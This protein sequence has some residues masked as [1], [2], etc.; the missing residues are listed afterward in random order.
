MVSDRD[1]VIDAAFRAHAADIY[2]LAF[3]I[4]RE[5]QAAEDVTQDT[6]ARAYDRF[7]AY[8]PS[9][10]IKGWLHAIATHLA[11]DQLRHARVRGWVGLRAPRAIATC[12]PSVQDDTGGIAE[13]EAVA[14]LLDELPA[15]A[16]AMLVLR[17]AY[18][19]DD[20]SIAEMVGTSPGNVRTQISRAHQRLRANLAS[21]PDLEDRAGRGAAHRGRFHGE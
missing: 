5:R 15:K 18:G 9:R 1:A 10:P 6:F 14:A 17:H 4:V 11:I 2:R 20:R 7:S 8:D 3:S 21:P 19:Y 16:R 13:R 12:E